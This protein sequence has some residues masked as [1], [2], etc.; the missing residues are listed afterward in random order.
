MPVSALE[1]HLKSLCRT[2]RIKWKVHQGGNKLSAADLKN[3]VI[4]TSKIRG[5]VTYAVALHE[6]GH[7]LSKSLSKPRLYQEGEAWDWAMKNALVW[8][9][10]MQCTMVRGLSSYLK[11]AYVDHQR[12]LPNLMRLPPREHPFWKHLVNLPE[13]KELLSKPPPWLSPDFPTI[14]WA[15]LLHHPARPRC[16]NCTFWRHTVSYD[17]AA[18]PEKRSIGECLHK[19]VPLGTET[20]PGGA[21]C[22]SSWMRA[23]RPQVN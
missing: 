11:I 15:N 13:A 17:R 12:G 19:A 18:T 9:R 20:T 4:H 2:H 5:Y 7:L 21:L 23:D 3:R 1:G 6:V 14:P 10:Q 8:N 22:G 16:A